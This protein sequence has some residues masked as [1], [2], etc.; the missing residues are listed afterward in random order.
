MLGVSAQQSNAT[1]TG[2]VLDEKGQPLEFINVSLRGYPFGTS[3]DKNGDYLFR[4]PTGREVTVLYS[5]IGYEMIEAN[6]T[7][8][9]EQ[10]AQFDVVLKLSVEQL[11][12]VLIGASSQ[13][14]TMLESIDSK[15]ASKLPDVAGMGGIDGLLKTLPGVFSNNEL[16]SQYSVRG[17]GFDENLVYVN[18]VEIYRPY[19]IRSGQQEGL[20]FVNSDLVSAVNFSAGGFESRYGDKM[21]SVLSITYK[22][23]HSFR[24]SAAVSLLGAKAH[25]EGS[26][27][28]QDF[29]YIAGFRY[30][31][32]QYL[33]GTLDEEGEYEPR[34]F[35]FQTYMTY[36]LTDHLELGVLG[37]Y[38]SNK[39]TFFPQSRTTETGTINDRKQLKVYYEGSEVDQYQS[40]L[41]AMTL[42]FTPND[43]FYSKFIAS[44]YN[45][46]EAET[47]DIIGTYYFNQLGSDLSEDDYGDSTLNLGAGMFH[48]HGRNFFDALVVNLQ[49]RGG[50]V[51]DANHLQWGISY[52]NESVDDEMNEWERRDSTGYSLPYDDERVIIY[53]T[54]KTDTTLQSNRYTAYIQDDYNFYANSGTEY[55]ISAGLRAHYWSMNQK[56][57][58]SPRMS[59]FISPNWQ[60]KTY[61][62]ISSGVY[63]QPP[64]Y[65]EMKNL[66]GD[67][68]FDVQTPYSIHFTAGVDY[69][70]SAWD[71]PFK[72]TGELYYKLLKDL[73]PYKIENV[74]TRYMSDDVSEGYAGGIDFKVSGEF[75]SG[76]QSWMSFS[77]MKTEEDIEGDG[78]GYIP[79]PNDQRFKF[80][81]FFQDYLPTNPAYQMNLSAHFAT[82]TPYGPPNLP[83]YMDLYRTSG[84]SRVDIGFL[85]SFVNQGK[86]LTKFAWLNKLDDCYIS[87]EVFNLL[88]NKNV[89]SYFWAA[90][91]E[92]NYYAIPNYLTRRTLNVKLSAAF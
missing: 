90:D 80:S 70:F 59:L 34:Y 9:P 28:D 15:V 23:P 53:S 92:S 26:A 51:K 73:I 77:L 89:S 48:E 61:F 45:S 64:F 4:I 36:D 84:Y 31:T 49:Y 19:L 83:R 87:V 42:S 41:A 5:G 13:R 1:L 32:N 20:S 40:S 38:S 47:Y 63:R 86:N 55:T 67:L 3:T 30:K 78:A 50:Y 27:A 76:T 81:I 43:F 22:K 52:K 11:D 33:L 85:R 69:Y 91:Y 82:G 29:T 10:N 18:D 65:Q 60:K 24:A 25:V 54:I 16:S 2:T 44:A 75:V 17:G 7:L 79:R 88:D 12:E 62:R 35:D 6:F 72:M 21:S 74:R 46:D 66:E 39:Y 14:A 37:N 8:K 58:L 68:N 57:Q 56:F 71:R